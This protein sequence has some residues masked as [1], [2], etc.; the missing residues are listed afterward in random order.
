MNHSDRH[1]EQPPSSYGAGSQQDFRGSSYTPTRRFETSAPRKGG[2]GH[3]TVLAALREKGKLVSI[4]SLAGDLF[5]GKIVANDLY[6]ITLK[7]EKVIPAGQINSA[8]EQTGVRRIFYKH[9]IES[10]FSAEDET[11]Q[12]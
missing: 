9:A 6:T 5:V 2:K 10:F 7:V 3:E 12:Q 11:T 8:L 4:V 1:S